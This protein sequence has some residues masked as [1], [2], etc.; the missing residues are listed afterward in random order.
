MVLDLDRKIYGAFGLQR[1]IFKVWCH[2]SLTYYAE[3]MVAGQQLP[4]PYE[5]VHDD[6]QQMG[7]DFILDQT[8]VVRFLYPSQTSSDRPSVTHLIAELQKIQA[9]SN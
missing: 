5:N 4:K 1:S 2:A 6:T 3:A 7:G 8:G 9:S